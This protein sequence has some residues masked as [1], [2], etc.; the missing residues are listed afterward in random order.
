MANN[1]KILIENQNA[2]GRNVE[3]IELDNNRVDIQRET[4][5]R[6]TNLIALSSRGLWADCGQWLVYMAVTASAARTLLTL[7]FVAPWLPLLAVGL[8]A[9]ILIYLLLDQ[10]ERR[11]PLRVHIVLRFLLLTLGTALAVI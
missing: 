8:P 3:Q 10:W 4:T 2:L 11:K 1:P 9:L 6:L 7:D 5:G